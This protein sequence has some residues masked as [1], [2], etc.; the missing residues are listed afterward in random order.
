MQTETNKTIIRSYYE[1][2]VNR[3]NFTMLPDLIAPEH[4][5]NVKQL[6][7]LLHTAFPD[8]HVALEN[9]I[10]EAEKVVAL[11]TAIGT[12][13]RDCVFSTENL[14]PG[15]FRFVAPDEISSTSGQ[16]F[17]IPA[18]Y[19]VLNYKGVRVFTLAEGKIAN[20]RDGWLSYMYRFPEW[21]SS[22]S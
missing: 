4:I 9:L 12:H 1:E 11:F 15:Y 19:K 7:S 21:A 8:F 16:Q 17:T 22:K 2:V 10:A 20:V 13:Q 6:I 14:P 3:A 5:E 18:S